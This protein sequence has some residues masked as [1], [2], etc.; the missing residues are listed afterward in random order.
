MVIICRINLLLKI[1]LQ[2]RFKYLWVISGN[3]WFV[4]SLFPLGSVLL[5]GPV[6]CSQAACIQGRKV[7]FKHVLEFE[8]FSKL[9][10]S[11]TLRS[12]HLSVSSSHKTEVLGLRFR[13][14]GCVLM[15]DMMVTGRK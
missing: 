14:N 3:I 1:T 8:G 13:R 7:Q 4:M 9:A 2:A 10:V 12:H 11:F 5:P 6:T 15:M